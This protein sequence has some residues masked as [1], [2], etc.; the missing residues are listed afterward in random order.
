[1]VNLGLTADILRRIRGRKPNTLEKVTSF[2]CFARIQSRSFQER[3]RWTARSGEYIQN[4]LQRKVG[5]DVE[6]RQ[7]LRRRNRIEG[8][9]QKVKTL[10]VLQVGLEGESS[11]GNYHKKG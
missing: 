2:I 11:Q 4:G 1:V 5:K 6:E 7:E 8:E 9:S 10:V 3:H